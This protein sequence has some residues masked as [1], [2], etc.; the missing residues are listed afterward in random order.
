MPA[1]VVLVCGP[2]CAGKSSWVRSQ[3]TGADVVI[4]LDDI[5][6]HAGS[7]EAARMARAEMES[8]VPELLDGRVFVIRTLAR[9]EAREAAA[10]RLGASRVHVL[11]PGR[12]VLL[13]RA[14]RRSPEA[15]GLVERWLAEFEPSSADLPLP[16]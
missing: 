15:A 8:L 14:A 16:T 7:R 1:E 5:E 6:A 13:A 11:N 3:A 10:V 12:D 9:R 2:P 4:D